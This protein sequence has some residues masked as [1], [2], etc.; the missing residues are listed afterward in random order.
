M[1]QA[2]FLT[3]CQCSCRSLSPLKS[4]QMQL[5]GWRARRSF[6]IAARYPRQQCSPTCMIAMP[7]GRAMVRPT[8][9][10]RHGH[11]PHP[12][13]VWFAGPCHQLHSSRCAW[14]PM[15]VWDFA[16]SFASPL[17]KVTC[18]E[19]SSF[20]LRCSFTESVRS[21]A[22][23]PHHTIIAIALGELARCTCKALRNSGQ[24]HRI[25][26]WPLHA[27]GT[28]G[29]RLVELRG[30]GGFAVTSVPGVHGK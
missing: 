15:Q 5:V 16:L 17:V 20:H 11:L 22:L 14:Q 8:C 4:Q 18:S 1:E 9:Q 25:S 24:R 27:A 13:G 19:S 10:E 21:V 26:P 29:V 23:H 7:K 3:P 12:H 2:P 30:G 28:S 6:G